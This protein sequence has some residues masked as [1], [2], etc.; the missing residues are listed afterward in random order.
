MHMDVQKDTEERCLL[1]TPFASPLAL[2]LPFSV[3]DVM[4]LLNSLPN[5]F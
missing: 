1:T 5:P 2:I 4:G 3:K